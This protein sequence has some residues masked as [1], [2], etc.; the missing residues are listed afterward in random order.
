[1]IEVGVLYLFIRLPLQDKLNVLY[2]LLL[3]L[4]GNISDSDILSLEAMFTSFH[5][6]KVTLIQTFDCKEIESFLTN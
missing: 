4:Q 3:L 1:M 2:L 6:Q 5:V